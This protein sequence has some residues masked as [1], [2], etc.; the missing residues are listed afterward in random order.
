MSKELAT[1]YDPRTVEADIADR[2]ADVSHHVV[3]EQGLARR[4]PV[5]L[6]RVPLPP[7]HGSARHGVQHS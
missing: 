4:L 1:Q 2:W 3:D 7:V 5:H 6:Y